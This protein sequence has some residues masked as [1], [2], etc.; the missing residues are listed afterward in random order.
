MKAPLCIHH[1]RE[2]SLSLCENGDC[3]SFSLRPRL[4][5]FDNNLSA[6]DTG[7]GPPCGIFDV[8]EVALGATTGSV[9]SRWFSC[10]D[11]LL[12]LAAAI[13]AVNASSTSLTGPQCLPKPST[14]W[15]RTAGGV[16]RN[17]GSTITHLLAQKT[18]RTPDL[19]HRRGYKVERSERRQQQQ[20]AT[21]KLDLG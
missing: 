20:R 17:A 1:G 7:G 9:V 15:L 5:S 18:A 11:L 3:I 8:S 19:H 12:L 4:P 14:S 21:R 2:G 16:G 13:C 10:A 6:S